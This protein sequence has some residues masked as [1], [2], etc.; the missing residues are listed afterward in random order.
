MDIEKAT[1]CEI[2]NLDLDALDAADL[3][4]VKK[5]IERASPDDM[6]HLIRWVARELRYLQQQQLRFPN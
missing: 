5:K 3:I 2:A 4:A 1:A 6:A